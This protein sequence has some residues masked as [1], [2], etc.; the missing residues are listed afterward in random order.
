MMS[1]ESVSILS[2]TSD[3]SH[4]I[5]YLSQPEIVERWKVKL[6]V[7]LGAD[8]YYI[9]AP[10]MDMEIRPQGTRASPGAPGNASRTT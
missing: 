7:N 3:V 8:T 1:E 6:S 5:G 10:G 2:Q 4:P 9:K